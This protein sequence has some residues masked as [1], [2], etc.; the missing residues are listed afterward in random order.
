VV[1]DVKVLVDGLRGDFLAKTL[2]QGLVCKVHVDDDGTTD[3]IPHLL[4]CRVVDKVQVVTLYKG[5]GSGNF[6]GHELTLT[7]WQ[8]T[9]VAAVRVVHG[10]STAKFYLLG[11]L[12]ELFLSWGL[13]QTTKV[14][15]TG[16]GICDVSLEFGLQCFEEKFLCSL[17]FCHI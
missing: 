14:V 6:V 2:L 5:S 16:L 4:H 17:N 11:C 10:D 12:H 8:T 15:K 7:H 3:I 1:K 13:V 9:E